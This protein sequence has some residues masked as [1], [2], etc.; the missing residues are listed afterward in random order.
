MLRRSKDE[1]E[2]ILNIQQ[3]FIKYNYSNRTSPIKYC[4]IHD[5]GVKGS[6]ALNN[7]NYFNTGNRN[8]SADFFVDA[9]NVIQTV[10][11]TKHFSWHCGDGKGKYGITNGNSIGI[12][13]CLVEPYDKVIENTIKLVR[14]LMSKLNIPIENVVRHYDSSRKTCP[15]SFSDNNWEKWYWFK[16]QISVDNNEIYSEETEMIY[17]YIDNNMPDWARPTIQKLVDKGVL[18]GDNEGKLCLNETMLRLYVVHD[19][20]GL[21]DK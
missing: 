14:H 19:R 2:L 5:V 13:M 21:Y 10:D 17:N 3:K 1:G 9:S 8:S 12:E 18:K 20:L 4:V 7:Y 11:Y 15:K 16:E 6:T